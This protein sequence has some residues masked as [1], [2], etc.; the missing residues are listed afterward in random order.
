MARLTTVSPG[1]ALALVRF[2]HDEFDG[3]GSRF[4]FSL[5][6]FILGDRREEENGR[7]DGCHGNAAESGG[8]E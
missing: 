7:G 3:H 8:D 2:F 4:F 1:V 6:L 5:I